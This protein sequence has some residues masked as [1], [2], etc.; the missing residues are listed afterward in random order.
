MEGM[1]KISA[2][3]IAPV[4]EEK[5]PEL[6]K[7]FNLK[8]Y[9][10]DHNLDIDSGKSPEELRELF[11]DIKKDS[12]SSIRYDWRWN[13]IE[14]GQGAV[15][16]ETLTRYTEGIRLMTE[17]GLEAPTIVLSSVPGWAMDLYKKNKEEF[18]AAYREYVEQVKNSLI[19]VSEET[20]VKISRVQVLNELNNSVYTP[21]SPDE[22]P[23]FC[24]ITREVF[25]DYNPEIKLI[26]SFMAGNS[27]ELTS[28][29]KMGVPIEKYLAENKELLAVFD[30]YAIDYYPG[31]WHVPITERLITGKEIFA[32]M[33]LLETVM[34]EIASWGKEYEIGE[35][36]LPTNMTFLS[37]KHNE[38]R[39]RYFYQVFFRAFKKLLL[40]FQ[41]RGV[42]LPTQVGLFE[43]MDE[44]PKN[45]KGKILRS[46]TPFPEHDFGMRRA[47][48]GAGTRKE[49]L[50][51]NRNV[52]P[53]KR[54]ETPSKLSELIEYINTPIRKRT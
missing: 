50:R 18:F 27:S 3:E 31:T 7:P 32:Q 13:R 35:V 28:K 5:S 10:T 33:G 1:P 4:E 22:L 26:G 47:G 12:I 23:R 14:P 20:G 34:T 21:F 49:I 36:G 52:A 19:Q 17:A 48:A 25:Q 24:A 41:E 44:P 54:D 42:A 43:A 46:V 15:E 8:F 38:D 30:T 39:Q 16:S 45:L 29:V 11:A 53:E 6:T 9:V 51:G 37:A 2:E 40:D